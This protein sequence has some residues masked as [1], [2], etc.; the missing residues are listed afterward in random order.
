MHHQRHEMTLMLQGCYG[1]VDEM[2]RGVYRYI[3]SSPFF[4]PSSFLPFLH[5]SLTLGENDDYCRSE[6]YEH[7]T[8][9]SH[10]GGCILLDHLRTPA[11]TTSS[12]RV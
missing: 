1:D 8:A 9:H 5:H 12:T 4:F 10:S 7:T 2:I 6:A 11:S 3:G